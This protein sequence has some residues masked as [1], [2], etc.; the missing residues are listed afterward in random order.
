MHAKFNW[1]LCMRCLAVPYCG[2]ICLQQGQAFHSI[3]CQQHH[4]WSTGIPFRAQYVP[5]E[6]TTSSS[7]SSSSSYSSSSSSSSS[8]STGG[9]DQ[10]GKR[11]GKRQRSNNSSKPCKF[12]TE[13]G[14]CNPKDGKPCD[15]KHCDES[16]ATY[17]QELMDQLKKK[18]K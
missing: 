18:S 11:G 17:L 13:K 2:R 8:S 5:E 14:T 6:P 3:G 15:Y 1:C 10:R 9:G 16:R 7:S 4:V 12:Y